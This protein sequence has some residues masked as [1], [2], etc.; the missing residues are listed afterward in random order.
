NSASTSNESPKP[1][2]SKPTSCLICKEDHGLHKCPSFASM[3]AGDRQSLVQAHHLCYNCLFKGHSVSKC[4]MS[5]SCKSCQ[6]KHHTLLHQDRS[7]ASSPNHKDSSSSSQ[8]SMVSTMSHNQ[9]SGLYVS[10]MDT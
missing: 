4:P 9:S 1:A 10:L 2:T 3:S 6:K 5:F 7:P 8:Q